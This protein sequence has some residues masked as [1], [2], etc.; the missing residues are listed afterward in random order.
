MIS[1]EQKDSDTISALIKAI[2]D[3]PNSSRKDLI[4]A[5][6]S[7]LVVVIC[8]PAL[9]RAG[10]VTATHNGTALSERYYTLVGRDVVKAHRIALDAMAKKRKAHR[11]YYRASRKTST[12]A[13][14]GPILDPAVALDAVA[15]LAD[16]TEMSDEYISN[17]LAETFDPQWASLDAEAAALAG[18][19][20]KLDELY[21]NTRLALFL[22]QLARKR[23]AVD[24]GMK[25]RSDTFIIENLS[26]AR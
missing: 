8:I 12:K 21:R 5:C 6:K 17:T 4:A 19:R 14:V 13:S 9:H 1:T 11:K 24:P 2:K 18:R 10:I 23:A 16:A 15:P 26:G 7:K 3:N 20:D 22:E 25:T